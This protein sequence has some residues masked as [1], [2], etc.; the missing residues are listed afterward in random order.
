LSL[1]QIKF[2][3]NNV[4]YVLNLNISG[5]A[6]TGV[7]TSIASATVGGVAVTANLVAV[8]GFD[9]NDNVIASTSSTARDLNVGGISFTINGVYYNIYGTGVGAYRFDTAPSA[10]GTITSYTVTGL[11]TTANVCFVEG[12]RILTERGEV[13]VQDL[14][15]GDLAI[16][17]SGARRPVKWLG[18]RR[19]ECVN[20]PRAPEA[21]PVRISAH[22]FGP[23]KPRRDLYVSP[24]HS[25]CIDV[26]GEVFI[27]AHS[28]INGATVQQIEVESVVYWHVELDSHDV[29]L[30]EN[31]P[32]ESYLEMNNRSFF[33]ENGVVSLIDAPD[34]AVSPDAGFCR[35]LHDDGPVVEAVRAQLLS[36][37][38]ALGWTL[39]HDP[40]NDLHL[41]V[42]GVRNDP[43]C[44]GLSATF[45][46]PVGASDIRLVSR[47]SKPCYLP[48]DNRDARSLGVCL[49]RI[50]VGKVEIALDDAPLHQGLHPLEMHSWGPFR[51]TSGDVPLPASLFGETPQER[52]LS[53]EM[54]MPAPA[55]WSAPAAAFREAEAA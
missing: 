19:I 40:L 16:T 15:V 27:R 17:A 14:R 21:L 53:L 51:W 55:S 24:G 26:L 2:T 30:A 47:T 42:D 36:R 5:T 8:G 37:A 49:R 41:V 48:G 12:T 3:A 1:D 20:H 34:G 50:S 38:K 32:A 31:L 54:L 18:H 23:G 45:D 35:P 6:T 28:L 10:T 4:T 39:E 46:V 33:A 11:S 22:A 43:L 7:V 44:D 29:L 25:L 13:A 52:R 9:Q